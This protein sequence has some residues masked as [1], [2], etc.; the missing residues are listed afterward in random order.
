MCT[1]AYRAALT[2]DFLARQSPAPSPRE[3][4]EPHRD[5]VDNEKA[6]ERREAVS[7]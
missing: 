6:A 5:R 3:A 4:A 7:R 1:D 2:E